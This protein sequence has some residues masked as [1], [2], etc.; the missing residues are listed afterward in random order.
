MAQLTYADR[1]LLLQTLDSITDEW[2]GSDAELLGQVFDWAKQLVPTYG[3]EHAL[4]RD[5]TSLSRFLD[6]HKSDD[7]V[8]QIARGAMLYVLRDK[9]DHAD[10]LR[11]FGLI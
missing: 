2:D 4:T 5:V 6:L 3:F 8:A 9:G 11:Q 1:E 7:D 10:R